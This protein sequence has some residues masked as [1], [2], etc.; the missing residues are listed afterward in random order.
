MAA[1]YVDSS[2]IVKLAV[3]EGESG[4]LRRYLRRRRA[5]S[6]ALSRTEVMR[7]AL[8]GGESALRSARTALSTVELIRVNDRVLNA[9]GVLLPEGLRSLDAIHLAT[10]QELGDEVGTFVTY[11]TRMAEAAR[12]LG[13]RVSAPQ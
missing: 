8:T 7:A 1:T 13:Y 5:I 12:D 11:D 3:E 9:A 4:A 2:A 10:A 6:S